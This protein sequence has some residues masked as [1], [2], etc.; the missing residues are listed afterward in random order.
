MNE[1]MNEW[2]YS[3]DRIT[4]SQAGTP[5]H[6]NCV[7]LPVSW[8]PI[9]NWLHSIVKTSITNKSYLVIKTYKT[10][11]LNITHTYSL[12]TYKIFL[13]TD[14]L[15]Q[16]FVLGP[17]L[18]CVTSK[19]A[20]WSWTTNYRNQLLAEQSADIADVPMIRWL[21]PCRPGEAVSRDIVIVMMCMVLRRVLICSQKQIP[22]ASDTSLTL[23]KPDE[24]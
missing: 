21:T 5:R 13:T 16:C 10:H 8:K 1:W 17:T 3:L 9:Y 12:Y 11:T 20:G 14:A 6:D 22:H 24:L 7:R 19:L 23:F 18:R 2:M 4:V 15:Y